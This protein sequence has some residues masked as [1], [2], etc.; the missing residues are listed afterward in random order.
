M[1]DASYTTHVTLRVLATALAVADDGTTARALILE[2]VEGETLAERIARGPLPADEA[3]R[4]AS[5]PAICIGCLYAVHHAR[6]HGH[7]V[8]TKE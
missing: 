4:V 1:Y 6:R 7:G 3:L 5:S 8:L 2:L